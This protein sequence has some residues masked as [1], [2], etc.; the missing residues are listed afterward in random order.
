MRKFGERLPKRDKGKEGLSEREGDSREVIL[1]K[2]ESI[3]KYLPT[4]SRKI[5]FGGRRHFYN[6]GK[7]GSQFRSPKGT[8]SR[9]RGVAKAS[10]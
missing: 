2:G 8:N 10:Y 7:K 5:A 4:S 1:K 9:R 6:D 3:P